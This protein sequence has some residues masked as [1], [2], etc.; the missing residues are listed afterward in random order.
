MISRLRWTH[1]LVLG[2][3][4]TMVAIYLGRGMLGGGHRL[5]AVLALNAAWLAWSR[6]QTGPPRTSLPQTD[7]VQ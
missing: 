1:W 2:L 4:V 3:S 6:P 5:L 7:S